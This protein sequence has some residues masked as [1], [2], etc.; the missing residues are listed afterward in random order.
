MGH[1]VDAYSWASQ[2]PRRLYK[3]LRWD[4]NARP[5]SRTQFWLRWW[6]PVSWFRTGRAAR[7]HDVAIVQWVTAFHGV[8]L[9]ATLRTI[10]PVPTVCVVHNVIPHERLPLD[11]Q[12]TRLAL[13]QASHI[14]VHS[15]QQL[16][17]L[18]ALLPDAPA[19]QFPLPPHLGT[20]RA[21]SPPVRPP[22]RLIQPGYV[23]PYKGVEVAIRGIR[24]YLDTHPGYAVELTIVGDFWEPT[25]DR[26]REMIDGLQLRAVVRVEDGYLSDDAL[27]ARI[28]AHHAALLP[29]TSAT[30]SG[31]IPA[32]LGA[33]RPVITTDVGG[34]AE[35]VRDGVDA[36]LCPPNDPGALADA[37]ET[38]ANGYEAFQHAAADRWT[39]DPWVSL[40][41][42]LLELV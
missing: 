3:G 40:A 31:L 11:L 36:I 2:Y 5:L 32:V 19:H 7:S 26:V 12:L 35:Q 1:D 30:Q 14:V 15:A 28:A 38:L 34:L 16:T 6:D 18:R 8:Q 29:Y 9:A 39:Q 22:L 20:Q 21:T 13:R 10:A 24:A 23:R 4:D 41:T 33:G 37:I 25:A 17:E 27:L 42:A